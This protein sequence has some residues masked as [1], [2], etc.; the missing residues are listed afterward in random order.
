MIAKAT[1]YKIDIGQWQLDDLRERLLRTRWSDDPDNASW[2]YGVNG[3]YL[4]SL[5]DYWIHDYDWRKVEAKMNVFDQYMTE[6]DGVNIHFLFK[7]G[8]GRESIPLILTHG[9][10]WS[11]WDMHKVINLLTEGDDS[12]DVVVPSLPGYGFSGP[13]KVSGMNFWKVADLWQKLMTDVLGYPRYAASGGDWGALVSSQI[14]HKYASSLYGVHLM[15]PMLLNQFNTDRPWDALGRSLDTRVPSGMIKF[16]SHYAVQVL[17]PQTLAF[18]LNDSPVGL[19]AWLLERW[20]S[21]SDNDGNV[22]DSFSREHMITNAMIYWLT[23]TVGSS[24][25]AYADAAKYPWQPSHDRKPVVQAPT[26]LTFLGGENPPGVETKDRVEVFKKGPR[27]EF[28]NLVYLN[29]HERGG[30]FG[31]YENPHAVVSDIREMFKPL[32]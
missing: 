26:G 2:D 20:R 1:P 5:T 16:V 13:S 14:G 29:A 17:D 6:I 25:R 4:R 23:Q 28:F 32:R 11:F 3:A 21:W 24:M 30:H 10:P 19:L 15:H 18:A 9:W 12:F 22:E 31:Y 8:R 7:K 27:A